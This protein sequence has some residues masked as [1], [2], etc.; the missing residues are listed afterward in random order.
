MTVLLLVIL[1]SLCVVPVLVKIATCK[2]ID[3][4]EPIYPVIGFFAFLFVVR[5]VV[6]L[7]EGLVADLSSFNIALSLGAIGF[8]FMLVGYYAKLGRLIGNSLL[9]PSAFWKPRNMYIAC[10]FFL[11]AGLLGATF[12]YTSIIGVHPLQIL[13]APFKYRI[14]ARGEGGRV[15]ELVQWLITAAFF[16]LLAN[17]LWRGKPGKAILVILFAVAL[18]GSLLNGLRIPTIALLLGGLI[19]WHYHG[20]KR[21]RLIA[22]AVLVPILLLTLVEL[23]HFRFRGTFTMNPSWEI[24]TNSLRSFDDF[25]EMVKLV[26]DEIPIQQGRFYYYRVVFWIPRYLWENKPSLSAERFYTELRYGEGSRSTHTLTMIGELY[27]NYHVPGIVLGMML[28]GLILRAVYSYREN[29]PNNATVNVLYVVFLFDAVNSF[30]SNLGHFLIDIVQHGVPIIVFAFIAA[31]AMTMYR[32][33][34]LNG[35]GKG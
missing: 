31:G 2:R 9:K 28:F 23:N 20:N 13:Q 3:I 14:A 15:F 5:P 17:R 26:P 21:V 10:G 11:A 33:T 30:R 24:V 19:L 1:T 25:A 12:Y 16:S 7:R 6:M 29:N 8:T 35:G 27:L 18:S 34:S 4:F 22:V 32:P